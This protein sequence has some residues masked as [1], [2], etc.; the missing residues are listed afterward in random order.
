[1]ARAIAARTQTIETVRLRAAPWLPLAAAV[2]LFVAVS[3]GYNVATPLYEAPDEAAHALYAGSIAERGELPRFETDFEYESWQPPLYYA[4]GAAALKLAALDPPPV[5]TTNPNYPPEINNYVHTSSEDFPYSEPVLAVHVLR[6][7]NTL[8]SAGT[9]VLIY[10]TAILLFPARRLLALTAASTAGLI[11][12]FAFISATVSNDPSATFFTSAAAYFGLRLLDEDRQTWLLLA[13][14]SMSLGALAKLTALIGGVIPLGAVLLSSQGWDKKTRSLALLAL[15][16]LVLA[17][18]FYV[19][20]I[21]LW[22][23]VYPVDLFWPGHPK[24]IWDPVYRTIFLHAVRDSF[25]YVGGPYVLHL[26]QIIHDVLDVLSV[27][28]L[29]GVIVSFRRLG[30]STFQKRGLLLLLPL[31]VLVFA[32]LIQFSVMYGFSPQGRYLFPA[33]SAFAI[34]LPL[35]LS[36]VFS[37]DDRDSPLMLALPA[38]LLA[39]NVHIFAITLPGAY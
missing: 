22:G 39:V 26:K 10:L 31:P 7:V 3:T 13:V 2:V 38:V 6:A 34:L 29:A 36:T 37:R 18:W 27:I 14:L 17:G 11:P 32:M 25:W 23:A 9:V 21:L 12:Q 15:G 28:G 35:G 8:F 5:L 4:V 20:S 30:L 16:P 1:M 19:R 33:M 24:P